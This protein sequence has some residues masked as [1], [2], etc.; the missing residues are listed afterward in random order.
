MKTLSDLFVPIKDGDMVEP[1]FFG[2]D[3]LTD[4]RV[5]GAQCAME[6]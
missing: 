4:E 3:R 2:G 6:K 5:N 1:V